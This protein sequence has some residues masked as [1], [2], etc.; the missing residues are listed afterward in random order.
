MKI[1]IAFMPWLWAVLLVLMLPLSAFGQPKAVLTQ[2]DMGWAIAVSSEGSEGILDLFAVPK[3]AP[4]FIVNDYTLDDAGKPVLRP[5]ALIPKGKRITLVLV[6]A[7]AKANTL[8]MCREILTVGEGDVDPDPIDPP[9]P[10]PGAKY[11]IV[12]FAESAQL[13]NLGL[14]QRAILASLTLREELK[15]KGHKLLGVFDPDLVGPGGSVPEASAQW[16]RAIQGQSLPCIAIAPLAGG[17][18]RVYPL[19]ADKV[20]LWKLLGGGQ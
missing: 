13:D 15:A 2:I 7:V 20:A 6:A 4:V 8:A 9:E 11:Q 18:I 1:R 5:K 14:G 19:P 12:M 3:D 10:E 17:D 16:F